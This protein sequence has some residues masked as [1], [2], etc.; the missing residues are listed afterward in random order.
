MT[1]SEERWHESGVGRRRTFTPESGTSES[2]LQS[3]FRAA[4]IGIAFTQA[5]VVRTVNDAMCLLMGYE[6][7]ELIG[8]SARMFYDTQ[9][10]FE[11][12]GRL[13]YEPLGRESRT[14][15]EASLRRKDG[16]TISVVL[17][18]S[19]IDPERPAA[20]VV[21]TV[22][23]V[24]SQKRFEEAL[25]ASEDRFRSIVEQSPFSIEILSPRGEV[26]AVSDAFC[27]LWHTSRERLRGYNILQDEE[28]ESCGLGPFLVRALAGEVVRSPVVNYSIRSGTSGSVQRS[29]QSD[30]YPLKDEAGVLQNV[31]VVHLDFTERVRSDQER[32]SLQEQLQQATKMEAVGR[33]AGGVAHDFNNLLTSIAGNAEL[34]QMD[35]GP[36]HPVSECLAE[37][38]K[39]A[40]SAAALTRQLLA[41]SRRQVIQ[42]RALDLNALIEGLNK[43][44][45]R[46]IGDD[47][48]LGGRLSPDLGSVRIDPGQFDQVLLN[49]AV[50]A[51]DAMP[52]GGRL[53]IET[54]NVELD[55]DYSATHPDTPPG[56]YVLLCVSDTGE[57]MSEDVRQHIFE[58]FFTTK[59]QGKGTGLGLATV[60]GI[61][62]QSS[63][64]VEVYSEIGL[65]TTF[66]IYLPRVDEAPQAFD[67]MRPPA[68]PV[69]GTETVLLAEDNSSVL[70]FAKT[71]L[72]KLGYRVLFAGT[73][74][75]AL[76]AAQN[77]RGGIALLITDVVMPSMN[78]RELAER[79]ALIHPETKVLFTSGYAEDVIVHHGVLEKNIH[80]ISKPYS[81]RSLSAKIRSTLDRG[82]HR[83]TGR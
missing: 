26:I 70:L 59:A 20:G 10:E 77:Y 67:S 36:R 43:M 69:G 1:T 13:L 49:L 80:F 64:T 60:F 73:G 51:N 19:L 5:R 72:D 48:V 40:E 82:R 25:R 44:L 27:E 3:L 23:D 50:N 46:V 34:A 22:Q 24:T 45:K 16:A 55:A 65:G 12:V 14:T 9:K 74:A 33:L 76:D 54:S 63:G 17:N 56:R 31:I 62:K 2:R 81:L 41:F 52:N 68:S 79:L 15:V 61:V 75:A 38:S 21:V 58:P 83:E 18:A 37:I 28:L 11:R 8:N 53:I 29:I 30:F 39:A 47:V 78:G 35:L 66:K 57:G 4:P 32:K 7:H 6:E 42:P 71:L